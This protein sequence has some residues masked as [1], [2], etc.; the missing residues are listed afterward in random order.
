MGGSAGTGAAGAGGTAGS[1]GAGAEGGFAGVSGDAGSAGTGAT[2]GSAGAAGSGG[3]AGDAGASGSAGTAG[4]AGQ[5]PGCGNTGAETNTLLYTTLDSHDAVITPLI[6]Q[7]A[8]TYATVPPANFVA[9]G[10]C[11]N[12]LR[13]DAVG[14]FVAY[15]LIGNIHFDRGTFD[16][17]YRPITAHTDGVKRTLVRTTS[18]AMSGGGVEVFKAPNNSF[19]VLFARPVQDGGVSSVLT[20]VASTHYAF[21]PGIWQRITVTWDFTV[22]QAVPSVRIYFDGAEPSSYFTQAQGPFV[23]GTPMQSDQLVIG[24]VNGSGDSFTNAVLDDFKVY[25]IPIVP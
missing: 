2:G 25:S 8:G 16:F 22:A 3:S 7:G 13:I 19:Q 17:W 21:V 12:A 1:A 15:P 9:S 24:A 11:A 4:A 10:K 6:G 23:I 14:E 18:I 20:S 5:A